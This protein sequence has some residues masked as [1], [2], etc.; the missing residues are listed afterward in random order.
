MEVT[1]NVKNFTKD[2]KAAVEQFNQNLQDT[3]DVCGNNKPGHQ[4]LTFDPVNQTL[5]FK[6][7]RTS[8]AY[9]CGDARALVIKLF[10]GVETASV[11]VVHLETTEKHVPW[12]LPMQEAIV[13][14]DTSTILR[15][16]EDGKLVGFSLHNAVLTLIGRFKV[17]NLLIVENHPKVAS[18]QFNAAEL[19]QMRR[20][21]KV[22]KTDPKMPYNG[23]SLEETVKKYM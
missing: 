22:F 2:A 19:I 21:L 12:Y 10:G 23:E 7:S 11:R 16:L 9:G 5:G 20:F 15:Y 6:G 17:E 13:N 14:M 1:F 18:A 3:L 8:F 4:E